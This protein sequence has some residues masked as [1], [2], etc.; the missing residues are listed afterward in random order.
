M[1]LLVALLLMLVIVQY[2][3]PFRI[4]DPVEFVSFFTLLFLIV[5]VFFVF[6]WML[7]KEILLAL[8]SIFML[9]LCT[10]SFGAFYRFPHDADNQSREDVL[11]VMSFNV[12]VFNKYNWIENSDVGEGIVAFVKKNA[13]DVLSIQEHSRKW[14]DELKLYPYKT[15]SPYDEHRSVQA[16]FSKYPIVN[17]GALN[18]EGTTNNTIFAD[19]LRN[20]DTIR[21]YNVHLQSFA[22]VPEV[23]SLQKENSGRLLR[24]IGRGI[25]KQKEQAGSLVKH[26]KMSKHPV[27]I[28]G[29][30]NNTQF[31]STYRIIQKD[32]QDTFYK[33]GTGFGRSYDLLHVP[34]RIDYI[35][36]DDSFEVLSHKNFDVA[37]SDHYPIMAELVLKVQE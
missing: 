18:P 25:Q 32:F 28:T 30:F 2:H 31:S 7:K 26:L 13:P 23:N 27:L 5:H 29:D 24:R 37:L 8:F 34:M 4:F 14:D 11:S 21:I 9:L 15:A 33:A 1:Q 16:I 3:F 12:R 6:I 10:A 19:I 36:A 35:L 22:V 20:G 17:K